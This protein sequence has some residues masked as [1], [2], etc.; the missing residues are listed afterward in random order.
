MLL[1]KNDSPKVALAATDVVALDAQTV[2][3]QE[4]IN[5]TVLSPAQCKET[6]FTTEELNRNVRAAITTNEDVGR[7]VGYGRKEITKGR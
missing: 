4:I 7:Y 3:D 1:V 2:V 5:A 6:T